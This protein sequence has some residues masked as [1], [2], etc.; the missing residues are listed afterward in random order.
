MILIIVCRYKGFVPTIWSAT[1]YVAL[2]MTFYDLWKGALGGYIG[3]NVFE[4]ILCGALSGLFAQ[5]VTFPG[6]VIRRR[7]Q[8]QGAGGEQR[9]Y[10]TTWQCCV[11][12]YRKEGYRGFFKG[13]SVNVIRC[14][15]GA[16]IQFAV[17]D[18]LKSL[19]KC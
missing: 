2:Q 3:D 15:P 13:L 5:T 18:T 14:L 4:K 8:V 10:H 11:G 1:P 7:M 12:T 19:L 16:G 9:L 6:D 17:Y